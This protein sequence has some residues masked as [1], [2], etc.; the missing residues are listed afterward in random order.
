MGGGGKKKWGVLSDRLHEV[1][2]LEKSDSVLDTFTLIPP[3]SGLA[4]FSA[5]AVVKLSRMERLRLFLGLEGANGRV[6]ET[7][8]PN[9]HFVTAWSL[10]QTV[11]LLYIALLLP[12]RIGFESEVNCSPGMIAFDL[13]LDIFFIVDIVLQFFTGFRKLG[14]VETDRRVAQPLFHAC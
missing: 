4:K 7:M 9:S 14:Q 10:L 11:F 13:F 3:I 1:T 2:E 8:H 12:F 5:P 6:Y